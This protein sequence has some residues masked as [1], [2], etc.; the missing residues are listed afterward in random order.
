[1]RTPSRSRAVDSADPLEPVG[2]ARALWQLA[3]PRSLPWMLGI[4]LF[5]WGFAH[6]DQLLYLRRPDALLGL[7]LAWA[8]GNTGTMWLNA[9]LDH[10]ASAVLF[11][12]A[13]RV[14][15]PTATAAYLALVA[16]FG[17]G[18][19]TAPA[20]LLGLGGCALLAVLYSHPRVAWKGHPLAGPAVNAIGYGLLSPLAGALVAT[21][22]ITPRMLV[23]FALWSLWMLGAYF[24]AQAFQQ[25]EDAARGYRTLVVTHGPALVLH[26]ARWC[27]NG[28]I[29]AALAL[30]LVGV[31]P[32]LTLLAYPW[33][34][35]SDAWMR[36][37]QR[38]P[39]GGDA[40]WATGLFR[41]MLLG[42]LAVFGLAWVDYWFFAG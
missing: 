6:W 35:V 23:T 38:Q 39:S 3:R 5:G 13:T 30:T 15:A 37:W 12:P 22:V 19:V 27:M 4:V 16:A 14:P 28:A 9:A 41:R 18:A 11:A 7:L 33:F 40:S 24:S 29:L 10:D 32:R 42:G 17:L 31:Y 8:L 20:A 21:P 34:L 25:E 1:M 36:R 2:L 26:V